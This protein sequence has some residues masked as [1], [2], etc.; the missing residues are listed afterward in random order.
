ML[1]EMVQGPQRDRDRGAAEGGAARG[2]RHP[3]DAGAAEVRDPR[4]RRAEGRAASREGHAAA[5]R[6]GR[7]SPTSSSSVALIDVGPVDE[8][9]PNSVKIV[10]AGSITVGVYNLN[11]EFFALEDR[12]SHD[13]GPLC[14][15]D[16]DPDTGVAICPRHGANIDIRTG[17]AAHAAGRRA[18]RH[19]SGA[20]RG[21]DRQGRGRLAVTDGRSLLGEQRPGVQRLPRRGVG[22]AGARRARPATSGSASRASSPGSR[23]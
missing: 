6:S 7:R 5:R 17:R 19:V 22:T 13:D 8:L 2:D 1:T 3:A 23:G 20:G 9:P 4:P 18:R 14:E 12:C 21:R 16:F 15:G 11:G 10:I